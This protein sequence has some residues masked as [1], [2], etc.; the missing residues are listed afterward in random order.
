MGRPFRSLVLLWVFDA[1]AFLPRK[2][3][4]L[5]PNTYGAD[6]SSDS[7]SRWYWCPTTRSLECILGHQRTHQSLFAMHF[8]LEGRLGGGGLYIR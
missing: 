1:A 4:G 5:E 2:Y 7:L 6:N 3:S 8:I